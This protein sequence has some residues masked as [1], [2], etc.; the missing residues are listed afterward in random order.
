MGTLGRWEVCRGAHCVATR[1]EEGDV[2][3]VCFNGKALGPRYYLA[4]ESSH[5]PQEVDGLFTD[6]EPLEV[7]L[8]LHGFREDHRKYYVRQRILNEKRGGA[9]GKW[10]SLGCVAHPS[11]DDLEFLERT[12]VPDVELAVE[13]P[14]EGTLRL[15]FTME[16]NELRSIVIL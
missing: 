9:L 6:L 15:R 3:I 16:P 4:E 13:A 7:E 8:V 11:R 12:S 5:T 1:E 14:A 2:R 10:R